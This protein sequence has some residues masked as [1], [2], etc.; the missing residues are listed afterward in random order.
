MKNEL[1]SI[2]LPTYKRCQILT[3]AINSV[4]DQT[5]KNWELII[6]DNNSNDGTKELIK[7]Y[8]NNKILFLNI[9]NRVSIAK[10][11]NYGIKKSK[12]VYLAFLDSDDY[13]AKN[14]LRLCLDFMNDKVDLIYHDLEISY[15]GKNIFKKKLPSRKL[16]SPIFMDL[17]LNGNAINLSSVIV[18]K[19]II[20]K[21]GGMNESLQMK[22]S[23]DYNTWLRIARHTENFFYLPKTLGFYL[24]HNQNSSNQ[25]MSIPIGFAIKEFLPLL[26]ERE[27][28]I[29]EENLQFI[30]SKFNYLSGNIREAKKKLFFLFN[31]C[32][33]KTKFK[34][35]FIIL[36]YFFNKLTNINLILFKL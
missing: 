24:I 12:G 19:N 9:K 28:K 27:K 8:D 30:S 33:L 23:E 20:N 6:I 10:S 32:N 26:N 5:Y 18:R 17:L 11:R 14:K 22:T 7:N 21:V 35:L 2:I 16:K 29:I 3:K 13:W 1:I 25:D 34:I 36:K 4:I 15:E 31:S